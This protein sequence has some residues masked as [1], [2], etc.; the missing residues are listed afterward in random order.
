MFGTSCDGAFQLQRSDGHSMKMK[1]TKA[2]KT[3]QNSAQR[4]PADRNGRVD[5]TPIRVLTQSDEGCRKALSK[6]VQVK[7]VGY[8]LLITVKDKVNTCW[9]VLPAFLATS[10]CRVIITHHKTRQ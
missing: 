4:L 6:F 1:Q 9:K 2:C 7:G 10:T 5:C 3:Q 8:L